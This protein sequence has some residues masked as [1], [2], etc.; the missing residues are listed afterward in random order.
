MLLDIWD[1]AQRVLSY[2]DNCGH[3]V[4]GDP[5]LRWDV[6]TQKLCVIVGI[7]WRQTRRVATVDPIKYLMHLAV[8]TKGLPLS[9]DYWF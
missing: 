7:C 1:A 5:P 6:P 2:R 9:I 3:T 8:V 4:L